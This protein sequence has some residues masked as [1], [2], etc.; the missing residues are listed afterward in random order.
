[1]LRFILFSLFALVVIWFA[2][3]GLGLT[4]EQADDQILLAEINQ[5]AGIRFRAENAL[6]AGVVELPGGLQVEMLRAGTGAVPLLEDSVEVHYSGWHID[7]RLFETTR[8][9]GQPAMI[10]VA[11][12]IPGWQRVLTE[13]GEGSLLRLVIPPELAYGRAG[14]GRI[15]AEETLIFELELLRIVEPPR[16]PELDALQL[17][18]PGLAQRKG[19]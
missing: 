13:V 1:M 17:P 6:R 19:S 11:S 4:P 8:R 16:P 9:F 5:E 7:G 18:V 15:G 10:P 12:T 2:A 3:R 14:G